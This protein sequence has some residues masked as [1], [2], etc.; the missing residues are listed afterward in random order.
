M[1]YRNR[2]GDGPDVNDPAVPTDPLHNL[3]PRRSRAIPR[4]VA[5]DAPER[6]RAFGSGMYGT[7]LIPTTPPASIGLP[8]PHSGD[9]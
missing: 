3:S 7:G 9:G 1:P 6:P 2:M 8:Q 4:D 5:A